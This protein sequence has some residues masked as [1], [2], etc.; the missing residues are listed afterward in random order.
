M[1]HKLLVHIW[2][3]FWSIGIFQS[4]K[5]RTFTMSEFLGLLLSES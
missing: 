5:V 3:T 1:K 2:G 4:A